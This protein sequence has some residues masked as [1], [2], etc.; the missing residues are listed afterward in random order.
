MLDTTGTTSWNRQTGMGTGTGTGMG[1]GT[2]TGMG[3]GFSTCTVTNKLSNIYI[4][5]YKDYSI[6]V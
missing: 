1:M 5:M 4:H 3:T 6:I 2:V